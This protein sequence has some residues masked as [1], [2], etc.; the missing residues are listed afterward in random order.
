MYL[1]YFISSPYALLPVTLGITFLFLL[2]VSPYFDSFSQRNPT[3]MVNEAETGMTQ[4]VRVHPD[5]GDE[6]T[7]SIDLNIAIGVAV[8]VEDFMVH[9]L[10]LSLSRVWIVAYNQ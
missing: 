7:V 10:I 3:S 9:Q 2:F 8:N 4:V 1:G 5:M 6:Y